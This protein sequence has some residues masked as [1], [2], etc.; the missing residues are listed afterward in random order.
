MRKASARSRYRI[1]SL[2]GGGIRGYYT[3]RLLE[4]LEREQ[5]GWISQF[6]LVAGTSTGAIIALALA[7]GL[8][9]AQIA[10]IYATDAPRVFEVTLTERLRDGGGLYGPRYRL[11][12]LAALLRG[13]FRDRRLKD[14][15]R[16]VVI[17]AFDLTGRDLPI[18]QR[19]WEVKVFHN[20]TSDKRLGALFLRKIALY[21]SAVPA[22]FAT[23]DGY[24][25]GGVYAANPSLMAT[26]QA[27]SASRFNGNTLSLDAF[28]VF[29]VGTGL[30]PLR[31]D[32]E[33]HEWGL[34]Q[35]A[36]PLLG[37]TLDANMTAT[38]FQA[39]QLLGS[40]Y[41]R[42]NPWIDGEPIMLDDGSAIPRL[43]EAAQSS[44]L[45]A[46]VEWLKSEW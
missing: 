44:D 16:P 21:S 46:A 11:G 18:G 13:V 43:E 14:L 36:K 1:L 20:L 17:P 35:W 9:P 30:S 31:I 37:L 26:A 39:E 28:R 29:S 25:D 41:H 42:L 6:D 12:R 32:G 19:R 23:I 8:T 7:D 22:V 5:P 45:T 15:S 33:R 10:E 2:D 4:R 40:A 24:I 34:V 38:T 27:L 3:A